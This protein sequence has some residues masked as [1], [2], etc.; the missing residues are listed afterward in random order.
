M[1]DTLLCWIGQFLGWLDKITGSYTIALFIFA[2]I[3]ELLLLP[4]GIKQQKNSINQARMRPKEMAIRKKYAG[5]N[6]KV[7]QQKM[8][9][10]IQE[11]Y[12][13]EN[14]NPMSGCLP[15]L[16]Q[17]PVI[18]ALYQVVINPLHYVMGVGTEAIKALQAFLT[19]SVETGGLGMEFATSN[20]TIG[21]IDIIR[22]N[23]D[24]IASGFEAFVN[25]GG[26]SMPVGTTAS[27]VSP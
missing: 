25:N 16:L 1:I 13:K 14:F 21:L 27:I 20:S 17:L 4:I 24:K 19:A 2:I 3:V 6:D 9:Q 12:Q 26:Y 23:W 7:T 22:D 5:R 15:M 18:L 8:T 11:M 10:E